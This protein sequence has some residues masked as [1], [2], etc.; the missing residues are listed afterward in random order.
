MNLR[1]RQMGYASQL[2][3]MGPFNFIG[4]LHHTGRL[5]C[6]WGGLVG[7]GAPG[8]MQQEQLVSRGCLQAGRL[9]SAPFS[10]FGQQ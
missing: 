10:A 8:T 4:E 2:D 9:Q 6:V 1:S 7:W 3:L 5:V